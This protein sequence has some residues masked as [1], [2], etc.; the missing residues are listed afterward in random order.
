MV[1][2]LV[3]KGIWILIICCILV[4][5][6]FM[7]MNNTEDGIRIRIIANSNSEVDILE[8]EKVKSEVEKILNDT[9]Q[10][11]A[12]FIKTELN[13]RLEED[14]AKK[15]TVQIVDS[16]YEAKTYD[17]KFIPSGSYKTLLITIGKGKGNNFWTLLYPEY[18][19]I[20]FEESNEVEYRIYFIDL[21]KAFLTSDS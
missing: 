9:N 7:M 4:G 14:L 20:E 10:I 5:I 6:C 11:D 18:Y 19:D 17:N 16:Q 1:V 12:L 3:K 21:L 2:F 15:I 8:K 13:K